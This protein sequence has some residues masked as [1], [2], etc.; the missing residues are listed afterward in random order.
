M[1][2]QGL[3]CLR[4]ADGG[5]MRVGRVETVKNGKEPSSFI[6][7]QV[8]DETVQ[9]FTMQIAFALSKNLFSLTQYVDEVIK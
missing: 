8:I 4:G 2:A 1:L 7:Q 9:S 6:F 5:G 3:V